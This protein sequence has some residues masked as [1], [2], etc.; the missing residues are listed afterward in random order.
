MDGGTPEPM[1]EDHSDQEEDAMADSMPGYHEHDE[2]DEQMGQE[3][4]PIDLSEDMIQ[5]GVE[6]RPRPPHSHAAESSN[7]KAGP[8]RPRRQ[9][10][11]E[12]SRKSG[13]S[14]AAKGNLQQLE[15]PI[16]GRTLETDNQ[17]LNAHIDFC[18]SKSAIMEAQSETNKAL[19]DTPNSGPKPAFKGWTKP[20]S[21]A[22]SKGKAKPKPSPFGK[23]KG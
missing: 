21:L 9:S 22:N 13:P 16:C 10:E 4:E 7:P 6:P 8:S 15:C 18:L 14:S 11:G 19:V 17:G 1:D 20:P 12:A 23:K 5:E 2:R 3:D